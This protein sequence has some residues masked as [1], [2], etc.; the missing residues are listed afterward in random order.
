M[1]I[2]YTIFTALIFL[3]LTGGCS[4]DS[5]LKNSINNYQGDGQIEYLEAPGFFGASGCSI[6]M[7]SFD[8]SEGLNAKY[9]LSGIPANNKNKYV[10]YLVV[11]KPLNEKPIK[12]GILSYQIKEGDKILSEVSASLKDFTRTNGG[13]GYK[14]S[15]YY[16]FGKHLNLLDYSNTPITITVDLKDIKL[17]E[18]T[19]TYF[20][21]KFGGFK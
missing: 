18:K 12:E 15:A 2:I 5:H 1:K 16:F 7:P 3:F 4:N 10:V 21:I 6:T 17:T 9:S 11:D 19:L 14:K 13:K 8:L 20:Q